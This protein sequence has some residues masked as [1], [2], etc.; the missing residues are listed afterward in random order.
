MVAQLLKVDIGY[1]S[2]SRGDTGLVATLKA[3]AERF[4]S[5]EDVS[6]ENNKELGVKA[7]DCKEL[8]DAAGRLMKALEQRAQGLNSDAVAVWV[9]RD[10]TRTVWE[11]YRNAEGG[12]QDRVNK[13]RD[14]AE[15]RMRSFWVAGL[16]VQCR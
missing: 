3:V 13:F 12:L 2:L 4:Q 5:L 15:V 8:G 6:E 7:G 10:S 9:Q 11:G 14:E 1:R 16:A